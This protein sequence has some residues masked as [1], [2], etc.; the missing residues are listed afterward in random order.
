MYNVLRYIICKC[1]VQISHVAFPNELKTFQK[2]IYRI[3]LE[4]ISMWFEMF[5]IFY[6]CHE[7]MQSR[8]Y[9]PRRICIFCCSV[10]GRCEDQGFLEGVVT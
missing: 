8:E 6:T 1:D 3:L 9:K 2:Y 7:I 4:A 10:L 5:L